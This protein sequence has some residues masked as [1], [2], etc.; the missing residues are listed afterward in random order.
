VKESAQLFDRLTAVSG[1]SI[2]VGDYNIGSYTLQGLDA[3]AQPRI[4]LGKAEQLRA[5]KVVERVLGVAGIRE[6]AVS[7]I[8]AVARQA[9]CRPPMTIKDEG[10]PA[11]LKLMS[12][13]SFSFHV[14]V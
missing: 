5:V 6:A 4:F 1:A 10:G 12:V 13:H 11:R 3:F 8:G 9:E 14:G 7:G 2:Q